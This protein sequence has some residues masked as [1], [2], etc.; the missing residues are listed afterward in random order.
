M[1]KRLLTALDLFAGAGGLS[2]GLAAAGFRVLQAIDND[3]P[4]VETYRANIG[5]HALCA[6]IAKVDRDGL[7]PAGSPSQIDLVAGGPPCQGFSIKRGRDP[8][9]SRNNLLFEFLRLVGEIRP[10]F[11]LIEN[12]PGLLSQ[13]GRRFLDLAVSEASSL[14]YHCHIAVL[15]AAAFGVPQ[16]RE[17]AFI[18]GEKPVRGKVFFEFPRPQLTPAR[19]KTVRDAIADLPSPPD[20]G[21]PHKHIA[22][23]YR[24]ARLSALNKERLTHIPPGGGREH[25]PR[26]LR[27]RCHQDT[28]GIRHVDTYGRLAW[29]EPSVTLTAR[30]DSFTRGRFAHPDEHRTITLREGA[31]LQG[32]PDSFVF[33]GN[34]EQVARQIGNAVPPLLAQTIGRAISRAI[35]AARNG[36]AGNNVSRQKTLWS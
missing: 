30:F 17:R 1:T 35:I 27:L 18:V 5:P 33:I 10:R 28:P 12:V 14:G 6:D 3:S 20:D 26:R 19:F 7:L 15:N 8:R 24:E 4:A 34:R 23:H 22:N 11:F 31:R 2:L 9:D 21:S 32:F 36:K 29:D 13:R 25:L 16:L